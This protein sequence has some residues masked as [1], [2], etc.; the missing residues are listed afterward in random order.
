MAEPSGNN[1]LST[2]GV[3]PSVNQACLVDDETALTGDNKVDISFNI[4]LL[5]IFQP[6]YL[7]QK[8]KKHSCW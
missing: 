7:Q 6:K 5:S 3:V 1:V 2:T 4:Y 8:K